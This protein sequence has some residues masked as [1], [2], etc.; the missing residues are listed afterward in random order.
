M[1]T[2]EEHGKIPIPMA[3]EPILDELMTVVVYEGKNA[4]EKFKKDVAKYM[5]FRHPSFLQLFGT[6]HSG[7]IYATIFYDV[8]IPWKDIERIYDPFPVVACY[9]YV[10]MVKEFDAASDYFRYRFGSSLHRIDYTLFLRLSGQLC[11]DLEWSDH[12]VASI[13]TGTENVSPMSLSLL[14]SID[15]QI[16]IDALTIEQYH[17]ICY[18][19]L[20]DTTYTQFPLTA[21][22]HLG[23]VYHPTG[24]HDLGNPVA[25]APT[26]DIDDCFSRAWYVSSS[27]DSVDPHITES[28]WNRFTVSQLIGRDLEGK[29][30]VY[31]WATL[32]NSDLWFSQANH[33]LNRLGVFSNAVNYALLNMIMFEVELNP[34]P[35]TPT[36]WH[37][38][39]AFLFL[40][41][42]ESFHV[43][44]ASFKCPECVGYWSFDPLGQDQ[45]SSEQASELGFPAI[46]ISIRGEIYNWSDTI[47][48]GLRQF[49]QGKG[50]D[51]DSQDVAPHLGVPLYELYSVYDDSM[52][53]DGESIHH[54]DIPA[55]Y[56]LRRNYA[57]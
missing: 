53:V 45:L 35:A 22:A 13:S 55:S 52:D 33:I 19:G 12:I 48:A 11:I 54:I 26:P 10:S 57:R 31:L 34:Q 30:K 56:V 2:T 16:I 28:G 36:D 21:T 5:E 17:E 39:N 25:T 23:A 41:P 37:S 38:S 42:P 27:V 3:H 1:S 9:I 44:P 49:H 46:T 7:N 51:P 50:F 4:E 32:Q 40:C 14:S 47:Y 29:I 24:H 18:L 15:T 20:R 6:V 43:G 8:L